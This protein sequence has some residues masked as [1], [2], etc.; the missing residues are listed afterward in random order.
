MSDI[1][2]ETTKWL[3]KDCMEDDCEKSIM[4]SYIIIGNLLTYIRDK[5][6]K[7]A[8][9]EKVVEAAESLCSELEQWTNPKDFIGFSELIEAL[10]NL[11]LLEKRGYCEGT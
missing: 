1:I 10:A 8:E 5:D 6:A 4:E 2:G 11:C 7:I 3:I 9:L